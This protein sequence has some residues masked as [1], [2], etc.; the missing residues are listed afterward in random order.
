[1]KKLPRKTRKHALDCAICFSPNQPTSTAMSAALSLKFG[2]MKIKLLAPAAEQSGNGLTHLRLVFSI[3][4]TR[5]SAGQLLKNE[6]DSAIKFNSY[7][8]SHPMLLPESRFT[9]TPVRAAA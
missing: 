8:F 4:N 7:F 1:M 6:K 5:T 9:F 2:L 3:V